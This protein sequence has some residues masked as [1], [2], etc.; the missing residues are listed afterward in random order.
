MSLREM[1]MNDPMISLL[2]QPRQEFSLEKFSPRETLLTGSINPAISS[3][4]KILERHFSFTFD[5]E[6]ELSDIYVSL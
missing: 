2:L 5:L 6:R 4:W 1:L 3:H